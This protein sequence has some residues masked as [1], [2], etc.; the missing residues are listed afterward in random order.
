M[1]RCRDWLQSVYILGS[2]MQ[3]FKQVE[4]Y[5]KVNE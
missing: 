2:E 4:D 1:E 5:R 3:D